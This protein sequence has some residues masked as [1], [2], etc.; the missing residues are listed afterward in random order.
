MTG[1]DDALTNLH[2]EDL[3]NKKQHGVM[4]KIHRKRRSPRELCHNLVTLDTSPNLLGSQ[5]PHL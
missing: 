5:F 4:E 1:Y 2:K 3:F